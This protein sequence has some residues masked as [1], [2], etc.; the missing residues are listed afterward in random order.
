MT[1]PNVSG[2]RRREQRHGQKPAE[3]PALGRQ[4]DEPG[5]VCRES[6]GQRKFHIPQGSPGAF[7]WGLTKKRSDILC[8]NHWRGLEEAVLG[9]HIGLRIVPIANCF[10]F[11]L[12]PREK[13]KE[14]TQLTGYP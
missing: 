5:R 9:A 12:F 3:R 10:L 14:Q 4:V 7:I 1:F 2:W 13:E 8:K 6:Q 11:T